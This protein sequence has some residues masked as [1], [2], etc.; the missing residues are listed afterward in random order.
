MTTNVLLSE[1]EQEK[2]STQNL[3]DV[4]PAD[5]LNWQPHEKAMTLGQ[6]ALHVATIPG[7][8][9]GFALD[10]Q[11]EANVIVQH[12]TPADKTEILQGFSQS[13]SK[14]KTVLSTYSDEW[15][16]KNWQLLNGDTV[17]AEMPTSGFIRAFVL[18]HWYH[19]RGELTTYLRTLN[20][21]IPSIYGPSA[22]VNP[23]Q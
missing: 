8:N 5:Q 9:L 1:L 19:H 18:N 10:G 22:D 15:L 4:L 16:N 3:L 23:F 20:M 2:T 12:P 13:I 7:R 21:K 17:L 11:V 6:L 14:A